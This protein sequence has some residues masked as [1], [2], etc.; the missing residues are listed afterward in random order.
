MKNLIR[1]ATILFAAV[2]FSACS[3]DNASDSVNAERKTD[4]D[5]SQEARGVKQTSLPNTP[6]L[7]DRL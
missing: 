4:T 3:S 2:L 7:K 5:K 6:Q 1:S